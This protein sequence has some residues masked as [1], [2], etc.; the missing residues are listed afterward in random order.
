MDVSI[1]ASRLRYNIISR[2]LRRDYARFQLVCVF[3]HREA[4]VRTERREF[5]WRE[6]LHIRLFKTAALWI[7]EEWNAQNVKSPFW[8]FYR[9][10][11]DGASIQINGEE[12]PL[13]SGKCYF[14]PANVHFSCRNTVKLLHFYVHFDLLGL[15]G[16]VM[17]EMFSCPVRLPEQFQIRFSSAEL[18]DALIAT[19]RLDIGEECYLKSMLYEALSICLS[20]MSLERKEQFA[21]L[22]FEIGPIYPAI[23][24]INSDI[25]RSFSNSLLASECSMSE[26]HFIRRFGDILGQTPARYIQERRVA[27]AARKLLFSADSI[28]MIA[29]ET[30]FGNRSYFTRVFTR[31]T[32]MSPGAYR[33]RERV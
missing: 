23:V 4:P 22:T 30:G 18:F 31:S 5:E 6:E 13:E 3:F 32:G 28:E 25:S 27:L 26:N 16:V 10:D 24:C 12:Y 8:R 29:D 11:S 2:F 14:V 1:P 20:G 15:P 19:G 9:N 7:S 21:R 17:Q 33:K